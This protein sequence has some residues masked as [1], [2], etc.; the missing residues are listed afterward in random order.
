MTKNYIIYY[1]YGSYVF[2]IKSIFH[3][4]ENEAS[5]SDTSFS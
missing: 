5:F 3:I 2:I 4:S 1:L